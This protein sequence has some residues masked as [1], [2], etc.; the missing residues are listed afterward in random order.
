MDLGLRRANRVVAYLVA[1]GINAE[2]L[3]ALISYG[4]E[5]PLI[6][7]EDRELANR[8]AITAV[9]G[10][11]TPALSIDGSDT[12]ASVDPDPVSVVPDPVVDVPDLPVDDR[13]DPA[14]D[15][16]KHVN[17]GRGNGDEDGDPGNSEGKNKGGDE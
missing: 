17:S 16:G 8:R 9:S 2:R 13:E 5:F 1:K 7:T 6:N 10:Y 12:I 15:G 11:F 3:E 14:D 4:E